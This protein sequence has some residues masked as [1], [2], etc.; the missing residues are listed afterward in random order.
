MG[1]WVILPFLIV[2]TASFRADAATDEVDGASIGARPGYTF[3]VEKEKNQHD[4][5]LVLIEEPK[6]L[7]PLKEKLFDERVTKDIRQQYEQRFGYTAMEQTMNAPQNREDSFYY[8]GDP[9]V[10]A[11]QYQ[12]YQRSFGNY[13]AAKVMETQFD[14]FS[15]SESSFK[16]LYK[17]KDTFSNAGVQS[18]SGYKFS[19][20]HNIS[21][22]E[23]EFVFENPYHIETKFLVQLGGL[24]P[25]EETLKV[26]YAFSS[27][28]RVDSYYT[29][30]DGVFQV[31]GT[32]KITSNIAAN[33]TGSQTTNSYGPSIRQSLLTM[34]I[35][36]TQ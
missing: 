8:N 9:T 1:T 19:W 3:D 17:F 7:T 27:A 20:H 18:D 16:G 29:F 14:K 10:T 22:N 6:P 11:A 13:V 32:R 15:K 12:D 35:S 28:Y 2:A 24:S 31:V 5:E 23:S 36:W 33:L 4:E 21:G 25:A 26:G 30:Y 34:G